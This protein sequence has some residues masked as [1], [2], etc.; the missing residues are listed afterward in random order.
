MGADKL[1]EK[2]T[3]SNTA[4]IKPIYGTACYG[5]IFIGTEDELLNYDFPMGEILSD[6]IFNLDYTDDRLVISRAM[7]YFSE[8]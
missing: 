7:H 2:E 5:I 1:L 4:V 3:N 8:G 6:E